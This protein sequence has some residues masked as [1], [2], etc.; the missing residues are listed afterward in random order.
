MNWDQRLRI[1]RWR[2]LGEGD[3]RHRWMGRERWREAAVKAIE[4]GARGDTALLSRFVA[5]L[6]VQE[7]QN[8]DSKVASVLRGMR[9]PQLRGVWAT[10]GWLLAAVV[11]YLL[12]ELGQ[13]REINLLALPLV[14]LLL[15]NAAVIL[16]SIVV[17]CLPTSSEGEGHVGWLAELLANGVRTMRDRGLAVDAR[18]EVETAEA[19]AMERFRS[20][21]WPMAWERLKTASRAWL[22][23][24]AAVM[25]IGSATG[26][27]AK[28]W[29]REYRAVWESTLL[30]EPRATAFFRGLFGPG[31]A[32]FGLEFPIEELP[33]MRRG[34]EA[35]AAKPGDALPWIHLYAATLGL[36]I[37]LPR[38][39]LAGLTIVRGRQRIRILW[40][41]LDWEGYVRRLRRSAEGLGEQVL[42]LEH[43]VRPTDSQR[44]VWIEVL[45]E[46]F[47]GR[48]K[49]V[50]VEVP[51][52]AGDDDAFLAGWRP[53]SAWVCLACNLGTT[54]EH[55]VHGRLIEGLTSRLRQS[56]PSSRLVVL[57]DDSTVQSR[58][59][60]EQMESRVQ[61]WRQVLGP[62]AELLRTHGSTGGASAVTGGTGAGLRHSKA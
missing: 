3:P 35:P 36:F 9:V 23:V 27:Y 17:E 8:A 38:V 57:L 34:A 4:S 39:L 7:R 20:T 1:L 26:L 59:P 16:I 56:Q 41:R 62:E 55:E 48:V 29:S 58:W 25:A 24:G 33:A 49:P 43:G 6:D 40:S 44:D 45:Q 21:A 60:A 42:I 31:A 5:N 47:G 13:E 37:V 10:L 15:W 11:G 19:R 50:F 54:P 52:S 18:G 12:T 22:H 46:V 30:N 2:A 32:V 51:G 14:G 61:L 53:E 28:G